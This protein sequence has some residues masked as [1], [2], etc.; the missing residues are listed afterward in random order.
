MNT[1]LEYNKDTGVI[2]WLTGRKAGKVAGTKTYGGYVRIT[3][4]GKAYYAH[5]LAWYLAHGEF[6]KMIDHINRDKTDNRLENL[7]VVSRQDNNQNVSYK[8]YVHVKHRNRYVASIMVDGKRNYIGSYLTAD[9]AH[10]AYITKK[11]EVHTY[12]EAV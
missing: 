8:G 7:R 3:V 5:R 11:E 10:K 4:N 1:Q 9:E 6:P 2:T 12:K